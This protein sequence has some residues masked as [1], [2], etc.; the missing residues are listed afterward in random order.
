VPLPV[1][2]MRQVDYNDGEDLLEHPRRTPPHPQ[3]MCVTRRMQA[4]NASPAVNAALQAL[5]GKLMAL[6][7]Y[8][9]IRKTDSNG[10]ALTA[11]I[12]LTE[13]V[14]GNQSRSVVS[15][16]PFGRQGKGAVVLGMSYCPE[17]QAA[18]VLIM[19]PAIVIPSRRRGQA[20]VN[21][22]QSH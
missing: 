1:A 22:D 20:V 5:D 12:A 8:V 7:P 17:G 2:L 10:E 4:E 15:L 18:T 16:K 14:V 9:V 13:V 11:S 19:Y 6:E 21:H 3:H